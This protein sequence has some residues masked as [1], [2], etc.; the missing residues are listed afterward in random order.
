MKPSQEAKIACLELYEPINTLKPV[1]DD[2]WIVDGPEISMGYLWLFSLPFT[3]RMTVIRLPDGGLW[4]HSPTPLDEG[5]RKEINALGPVSHIVA[6]NRIHYWWVGDWKQAYPE[7]HTYAA[8]KVVQEAAKAGRFSG[9]D[10]ELTDTPPAAWAGIIDQQVVP[11]SYLSEAVFF[12]RPSRTLV[13]TDLIENF[14]PDKVTCGWLKPM[15]KIGGVADPNG[16][17]P[18][19]LRLTFLAQR[20]ELRTAVQKMIDWNPE[21]LLLA[22]G[23]WYAEGAVG[24]LNRAFRWIL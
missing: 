11:G 18:R 10:K 9:F 12:H 17:M 6:P 22:H 13:L 7:A 16:T 1:A 20:K 8:P 23:R 21:R 19:D 5:L 2:V 24:E 15:L 4:L 14:E 3:T